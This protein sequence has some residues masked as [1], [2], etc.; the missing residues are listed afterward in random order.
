MI[1]IKMGFFEI[2][3][4][5]NFLDQVIFYFWERFFN[6]FARPLLKIKIKAKKIKDFRDRFLTFLI[7]V[8]FWSW[9]IFI[10]MGHFFTIGLFQ[11]LPSSFSQSTPLYY[12]KSRKDKINYTHPYPLFNI[13]YNPSITKNNNKY[14]HFQTLLITL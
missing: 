10:L 3:I 8:G 1:L 14:N 2:L 7:L 5:V 6:F 4:S 13:L 11:L 12:Q 9:W